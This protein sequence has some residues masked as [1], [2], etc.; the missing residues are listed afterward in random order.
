MKTTMKKGIVAILMVMTLLIIATPLLA[1]ATN[2]TLDL[3]LNDAADIGLGNT[4]LKDTI[5]QVIK[6]LLSFLGILAVIIILWGGFIWMTALGDE[7]KVETAKK[8]IVAG[9]IGIVII[10]AAYAIAY[11]VISNIQT[12]TG[13]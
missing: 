4:P 9:I 10:L 6:V 1:Q 11:F 2:G 7:G 12:A 13:A 3:G 5:N 8:L